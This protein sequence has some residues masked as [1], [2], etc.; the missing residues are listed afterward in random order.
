MNEKILIGPSSFAALN[1]TPKQKLIDAGLQVIDNPFKRKL[2]KEELIKLLPGVIGVI[3]GLE[4]LDREV[5]EKSDL[6]V[7]SRCG[8]G[9]SNVD[10]EAAQDL[11]VK[12]YS[13][14]EAPV[15]AVAELTIGAML[16]LLRS[17]PHMNDD[18]HAGGWSKK[19]GTQLHGKIVAIIG[20]GRIGSYVA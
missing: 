19:I 5:M 8:S 4:P 1:Y 6:K 13:T 11:G 17:I 12:V 2:T 18:L 15:K 9:M 16:S 3:A 7:I 20:Y 10:E 14:P